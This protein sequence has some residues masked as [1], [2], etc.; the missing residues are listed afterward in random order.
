MYQHYLLSDFLF[1][2]RTIQGK[3]RMIMSKM[4]TRRWCCCCFSPLCKGLFKFFIWNFHIHQRSCYFELFKHVVCNCRFQ[5][6]WKIF[7]FFPLEYLMTCVQIT[8]PFEDLHRLWIS[9]QG[10]WGL[11]EVLLILRP[12]KLLYFLVVYHPY[13]FISFF[14]LVFL[15]ECKHWRQSS[16]GQLLN[17][18]FNF[19]NVLFFLS[20]LL[21]FPR[22]FA[23]SP[24]LAS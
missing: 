3:K 12:D 13:P 16:L 22:I 20:I 4:S 1:I 9:N 6:V 2:N 24:C 18:R 17:I 23:F 15:F 14:F 19:L 7:Q 8:I 10:L 21:K 11:V 5:P